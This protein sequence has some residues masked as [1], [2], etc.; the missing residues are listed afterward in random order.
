MAPDR[1]TLPCASVAVP[2]GGRVVIAGDLF[3][4]ASPTPASASAAR[5]LAQAVS[6]VSG[7]GALLVAG[8]LFEL[9]EAPGAEMA[10]S[11]QA[12]PELSDV[13][14]AFLGAGDHR[15]V[16]LP[17]TRDRAICYD[18]ATMAELAA[19]GIEVA[20]SADL[21]VET[22]SG[23]QRVRVE[24]GWRYDPLNAFAD[25][26]DP[27]DTPLG[28]HAITELFPSLS[29]TR[30]GWLEGID[31]LADPAGMPRFVT[32]RLMYRRLGRYAWWLLVPIVVAVLARIPEV[33]LFGDRLHDVARTLRDV[34]ITLALELVVIGILLAVVNHRVWAGPGSV[35]LGPPGDRANDKAR[36]AARKLVDEGYA[37]LVTG[38]TLRA[39]LVSLGSGFFANTGACAELVEERRGAFGMP[40]VFVRDEQISFVEIDAGCRTDVQAAADAEARQPPAALQVRLR[41]SRQQRSAGTVFERLAAGRRRPPLELAVVA[42][43]PDGPSWPPLDDPTRLRKRIRRAAAVV[44]L[45]SGILDLVTALVPVQVR[46]RLHPYLGYIPLGASEA[47]GAID[48]LAGIALVL[49]ARGLRRGQRLAFFVSVGVEALTSV[50]HIVRGGQVLPAIFALSVLAGLLWGRDSFQGRYDPPSIRA[51]FL[52]LVGGAVGVTAFTTIALWLGVAFYRHSHLHTTVQSL[53]LRSAF[54]AAAGGLVGL[55][56]VGLPDTVGDFLQ[57][58]LL[59][60]GLGLA[61]VALLLVFRPVVDRRLHRRPAGAG[62]RLRPGTPATTTSDGSAPLSPLVEAAET[63]E[64]FER[65]RD[66]VMRRGGTLDYF[67]LRSDKQHFFDRDSVVA[68][69]IRSGVCLVS[70]DPIGP[71]EERERLWAGFRRFADEHGWSISVL[72]AGEEWVP[73]YRQSGMRDLYIGDEG[74]VDVRTLSL[75]GGTKKGLRQAVNRIA[76]YGYTISFHDP[77][78]VDDA[79]AEA[80]RSVMTQSRRGGV[81]R[82]FS[83]TLGR[84]FDPQDEGLLLAVASDPAGKAVAFCQFVPAPAIDGYSLDL[85]RRDNGDHP[86]GL[87]DFILVRTMEH[88]REEGRARLGLNFA[89]MR[90]VLAGE[91]GDGL[92]TKVERWVLRRM[93]DSMQIESLW[94]FNA[95]FDPEWLP[96]FVVWD[97]A[98]QSLGAALAIAKA[99]SFWELPIIGRFL[100][101]AEPEPEPQPEPPAPAATSASST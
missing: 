42:C 59:A 56:P 80:L 27:R 43:V 29:A 24:P 45:L 75:T 61:A 83:M 30:T 19:A 77:N 7:P 2:L 25:P 88:L 53:P 23:T 93:S 81:E 13:V 92:S 57:P 78:D 60:I 6:G 9:G 14:R 100:V 73:I 33:A 76:K 86:N 49:L 12:H 74:V 91:A 46:G 69:A 90:A 62:N 54:L 82:G 1:C 99:E 39:E 47:A 20:L 44:V 36:D 89:M 22:A 38:H 84:I 52:T 58:A 35:L 11:L 17:G 101:P 79:L 40:P 8:N 51:G 72:A 87:F 32:S 5:E 26:T 21:E 41:L 16:L 50:L 94:R 70:P 31:R 10:A 3:L 97:S 55:S 65:A 15:V 18:P 64:D 71:P 98:E 48:A 85:M 95:K 96:R 68:Y 4:S 63:P 67:A 66:I 28:H 34:A 37:G